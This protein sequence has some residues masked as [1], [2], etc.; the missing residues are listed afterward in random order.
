MSGGELID[1]DPIKP[2][3]DLASGGLDEAT[4][5]SGAKTGSTVPA[6]TNS[7]L[8]LFK[9]FQECWHIILIFCA[10]GFVAFSY[11]RFDGDI[12]R[13]EKEIKTNTNSIDGASTKIFESEKKI[14]IVESE[15]HHLNDRYQEARSDIKDL[16][17]D[18]S[19]IELQN[20]KN[21]K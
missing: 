6:R 17:A 12:K 18:L 1:T 3:S 21:S 11:Y 4:G 16:R 9:W 2:V 15:I 5:L 8:D 20:A 10:I 13:A 14:L 19:D 7:L